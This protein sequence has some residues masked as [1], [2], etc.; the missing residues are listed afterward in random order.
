[1]SLSFSFLCFVFFF[2]CDFVP[3]RVS[4]CVG[5]SGVSFSVSDCVGGSGVGVV[6]G[7]AERVSC[8]WSPCSLCMVSCDNPFW[9]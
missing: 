1:M 5:G 4:D 8:E 7:G 6:V 2:F 3:F 9:T